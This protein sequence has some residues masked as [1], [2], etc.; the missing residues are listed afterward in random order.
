MKT[1]T[2]RTQYKKS[3]VQSEAWTKG[4]QTISSD[5]RFRWGSFDIKTDG[6]EPPEFDLVNE[7]GIDIFNDTRHFEEYNVGDITSEQ[8]TWPS[9]MPAKERKKLQKRFE[10]ESFDVV[11]ESLDGWEQVSNEI[12]FQGPLQLENAAGKVIRQGE[13]HP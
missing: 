2:I 9:D 13:K 1:W 5:T 6:K 3:I 8:V 7:N 12:I 4:E 10:N 11:M